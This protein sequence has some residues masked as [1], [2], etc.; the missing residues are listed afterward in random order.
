MMTCPRNKRSAKKRD[1]DDQ[2]NRH[3]MKIPAIIVSGG[4]APTAISF[5]E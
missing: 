4:I 1:Q 2:W 3:G 5:A